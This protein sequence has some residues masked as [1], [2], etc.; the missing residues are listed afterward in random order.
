M[1]TGRGLPRWLEA[2]ASLVVLVLALPLLGLIALLVALSSRGPVLFRQTRVGKDGRPFELLKFRSMRVGN[3]GPR[4]TVGG[5]SR[6]T[7]VGRVL[8]ATKLDEL[9]E[10]WNVVRG[11]MSL[12]G[13]RPELPDY[14]DSGDPRRAIVLAVRPGITD[15]VTLA[16][17]NEEELLASVDGDRET[18]YCEVLRPYKLA[19]YA[20]YLRK[21]TWR[22]DVAVLVATLVAGVFP[23]RAPAPTIAELRAGRSEVCET[24]SAVD[25]V[26]AER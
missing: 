2:G 10:L 25:V 12:V 13:P 23:G 26:E 5:D 4:I 9:P 18:F 7:A 17:R 20:E 15:P 8:R 16:L 14:V 11:D 3:G 21:R 19:G 1:K 6:V 24:A 22:S